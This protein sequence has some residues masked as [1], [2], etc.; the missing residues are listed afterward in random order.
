MYELADYY[1][2]FMML[3]EI[4]VSPTTPHVEVP[5]LMTLCTTLYFAGILLLSLRFIIQLLSICR[6]R[7]MGKTVYLDG[8]RV[9]SLSTEGNPFS[10]FGWIFVYLPTLKPDSQG[11]IL[12]H[13]QTHARQWHSST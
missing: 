13:E 1:A 6:M 4:Y 8:Q 9:I 3:E 12:M 5:S 2:T 10:F 7:R 11:E